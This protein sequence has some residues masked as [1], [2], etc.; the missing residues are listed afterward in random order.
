MVCYHP[1]SCIYP[2]TPNDDGKRPL[3]F[4]PT[5]EMRLYNDS[6]I[7]RD[8]VDY[9]II[10]GFK[11]KVPCGRCIGCRLDYSRQWALRSMHE[12]KLFNRGCFVTLTFDNE[13]L[14]S[15]GSVHK[16][17]IQSWLKR[18]RYRFGDDIRYLLCGEYGS[19]RGRPHYHILFFNFD[20]PDKY[21]W[22]VRKGNIYYRS[23]LLESVWR[24]A[25]CDTGNGFSVIGDLTAES[26]AY[27]S[28]YITKKVFGADSKKF[29]NGLEPEFQLM[30]RMPGLGRNY[31]E[32]Y[33]EGWFNNGFCLLE[34][35]QGK[36]FRVQIPRYYVDSMKV[37]NE[38]VY[39]RYKLD[40]INFLYE[41]LFVENLDESA[42]RLQVREELKMMQ[43]DKLVRIYEMDGFLHN[44]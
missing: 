31:L 24:D 5:S 33:Y 9:S 16:S 3:L 2:S 43:F 27:V 12:A 30:S 35:S 6:P 18:F 44:I 23:P 15:D 29:Y 25:Y 11:I 37:I 36:K 19:K 26:C 41:N 7:I 28:R 34:N 17:Y 8:M 32:K 13:H 40:R 10:R 4:R 42:E 14:P 39:N 20:F 1:L 22:T 21:P 38:D